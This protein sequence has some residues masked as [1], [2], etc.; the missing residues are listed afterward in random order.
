[1][2]IGYD[3]YIRANYNTQKLIKVKLI[4]F[5]TKLIENVGKP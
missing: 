2:Q 5:N 1:M 3:F 4:F